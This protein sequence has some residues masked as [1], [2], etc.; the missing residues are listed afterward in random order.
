MFDERGF[1]IGM[2][3]LKA[4]IEGVGFAIPADSIARFLV[5]LTRRDADSLAIKR[6]WMNEFERK[7]LSATYAGFSNGK[8][9]LRNEQGKNFAIGLANLNKADR[10]FLRL[11]TDRK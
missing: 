8:V 2:V 11:L 4:R 6:D 10:F 3:V 7:T 9:Q 5:K 1:V